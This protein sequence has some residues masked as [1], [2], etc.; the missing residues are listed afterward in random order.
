LS[1]CK[2]GFGSVVLV[3]VFGCVIFFMQ[4]LPIA[5]ARQKFIISNLTFARLLLVVALSSLSALALSLFYHGQESDFRCP[6]V[7][8]FDLSRLACCW[9][10]CGNLDFASGKERGGGFLTIDT[11]AMRH[12]ICVSMTWLDI[13]LIC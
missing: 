2:R 8:P 9:L 6:L 3:V 10:L 7:N 11:P 1:V 13:S 5:P 12:I 4:P